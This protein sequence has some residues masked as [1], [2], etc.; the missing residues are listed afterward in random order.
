[1]SIKIY[2]KI[3]QLN[4]QIASWIT[5]S[6]TAYNKSY[7]PEI[8]V[9]MDIN[10]GIVTIQFGD[11]IESEIEKKGP[12]WLYTASKDFI[13]SFIFDEEVKLNKCLLFFL[14]YFE[15]NGVRREFEWQ[16]PNPKIDMEINQISFIKFLAW[17]PQLRDAM[18]DFHIG[19]LDIE[20]SPTHFYRMVDTLGH[21]VLNKQD[22]LKA[23]DWKN[24]RE[25]IH[26][27][28]DEGIELNELT[29]KAKRY[30]HGVR[31]PEG[32]PDYG[33]EFLIS[34]IILLR[35]Y[36]YLSKSEPAHPTL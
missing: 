33:K 35:S 30:R 13:E 12:F 29:K 31:E 2:G 23:S 5:K 32:N 19:L 10:K 3:L 36:D 34:K 18:N 28:D 4:A 1:M 15:I 27:T 8:R 17:R 24:F 14:E 21:V 7:S 22:K 11:E 20:N 25:K 9:S 6:T 26:L 16:L